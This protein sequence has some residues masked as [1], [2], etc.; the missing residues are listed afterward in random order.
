MVRG[1][2]RVSA[3]R[4]VPLEIPRPPYVDSRGPVPHWRPE[5]ELD[6]RS[7]LPR[8]PFMYCKEIR[9]ASPGRWIR[10]VKRVP[11]REKRWQLVTCPPP[12]ARLGDPRATR[13][14]ARAGGRPRM[15]QL[16]QNP[17]NLLGA[18]IRVVTTFGEEIE[19]ELFCVDIGGS[20]SVV[21]CQRLENGHVNYKWTKTN[22]IREVVATGIPPTGVLEDCAQIGSKP[23]GS[24][25]EASQNAA[26]FGVG[27]TEQAQD[28]FDALSKTMQVE[29]EGEDIK[30]MGCKI[31][32]PYASWRCGRRGNRRW[33]RPR[34]AAE[35]AGEHV[36][37]GATTDDVDA[38]VHDFVVSKNAYPSPLG[39]L[40]FPKSVS[41]SVNDIIAHGI[42]DDRPLEEGDFLNVDVTVFVEGVHGDTS[43]MFT[44]GEVDDA[45]LRLCEA[46]QRATTAGIEVCGPGVDFRCVG[47]SLVRLIRNG[48]DTLRRPRRPPRMVKLDGEFKGLRAQV[49]QIWKL[50]DSKGIAPRD[51]ELRSAVSVLQRTEQE[52]RQRNTRAFEGLREEMRRQKQEEIMAENSSQ[53]PGEEE[54]FQ[55]MQ[56]QQHEMHQLTKELQ[57]HAKE[58]HLQS[59]L[60]LNRDKDLPMTVQA[61][62]DDLFRF[63]RQIYDSG[64]LV[65][66]LE[67]AEEQAP[68][69]PVGALELAEDVYSARLLIRLLLRSVFRI[70]QFIAL[71]NLLAFGISKGSECLKEP[72]EGY[73]WWMLHLS[74]AAGTCVVGA[75]M[76]GRIMDTVNFLMVEV[77]IERA[78]SAEA[79][80]CMFFRLTEIVMIILCNVAIFICSTTPDGVWLSITAITFVA[81]LPESAVIMGKSGALGH[82]ISKQL[83]EM[84]FQLCL[85][86]EYPWW[87]RPIRWFTHLIMFGTIGFFA[88]YAFF[89][90]MQMCPDDFSKPPNIFL[91]WMHDAP[92][93]SQRSKRWAQEVIPYVNDTDQGEMLPGMTFTVEPVLVED[94]DDSYEK[95]DD[96]WTFQTLTNARS[97]QMPRCG[98]KH[99][100]G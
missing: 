8:H 83:T 91:E 74:K 38:A 22:I 26:R 32:K 27:V 64:V 75:L 93:G 19:G 51:E 97:A 41:T 15:S 90:P 86:A 79:I 87:F 80:F 62:S 77:L 70:L 9:C 67:V 36:R 96:E 28:C 48:G 53:N 92:G 78:A 100:G 76:S 17:E 52:E 49:T 46:A 60:G 72:L 95:W 42:P 99:R 58:L 68:D 57:R 54:P 6:L 89:V 16:L 18:Q 3:V 1:P 39:Y 37:P 71:G 94:F 43:C 69:P 12:L 31:S 47:D 7:G 63:K 33:I 73:H 23:N 20:N 14:V 25:Q 81:D 59:K 40:G 85:G 61:V 65:P 45:G 56:K 4:P 29:W 24:S 82:H 10:C 2:G 11:L 34:N 84:Q 5:V 44:V 21:L 98:E 50:L 66:K 13:D 55:E 30:C 88:C 35:V